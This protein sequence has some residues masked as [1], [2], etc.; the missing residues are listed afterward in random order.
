MTSNG[1]PAPSRVGHTN[2]VSK[3]AAPRSLI[4][5]CLYRVP[6]RAAFLP[7]KSSWRQHPPLRSQLLDGMCILSSFFYQT[8]MD[9]E[10]RLVACRNLFEAN[11]HYLFQPKEKRNSIAGFRLSHYPPASILNIFFVIRNIG[12]LKGNWLY[13]M[14]SMHGGGV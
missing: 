2:S 12:S 10:L 5:S 9:L 3:P 14:H 1:C 6:T 8:F 7:T 11:I 13:S 4:L